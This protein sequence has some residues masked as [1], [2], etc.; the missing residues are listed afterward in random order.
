MTIV[1]LE[2]LAAKEVR[3]VTGK[4]AGRLEEVHAD[5]R[6]DEVVVTHYVLA[7]KKR[8]RPLSISYLLL[9]VLREMGAEKAGGSLVVP[10]DKMDLSDPS[11]PRLTC[12]VEELASA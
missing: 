8:A 3:D 1:N 9:F 4:P 12:R 6:G 11:K 10:W 5:W 7:S 2:L